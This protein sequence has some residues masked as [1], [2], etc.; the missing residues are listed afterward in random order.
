MLHI[1]ALPELP[2][3]TGSFA[4]DVLLVDNYHQHIT[5]GGTDSPFT[6][7]IITD[8]R[9]RDQLGQSIKHNIPF[10]LYINIIIPSHIRGIHVPYL[11]SV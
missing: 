6:M 4:E 9:Y 10:T 7:Y 1:P 8:S 11:P 2:A 5:N 3:G